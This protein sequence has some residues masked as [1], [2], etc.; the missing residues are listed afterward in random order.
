MLLGADSRV[1]PAVGRRKSNLGKAAAEIE[2]MNGTN[3]IDPVD[4]KKL[5]KSKSFDRFA[6]KRFDVLTNPFLVCRQKWIGCLVG[7]G[8]A[9]HRWS[10]F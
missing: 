1:R 6:S 10:P 2:L 3:R 4:L 8:V 9:I 5:L 7:D